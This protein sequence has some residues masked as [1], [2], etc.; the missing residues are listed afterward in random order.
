MDAR[1]P[2]SRIPHL[3]D[4]MSKT[5]DIWGKI[6]ESRVRNRRIELKDGKPILVNMTKD[7]RKSGSLR[8]M[9]HLRASFYLPN[10]IFEKM[11]RRRK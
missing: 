9:K 3:Y 7:K 8:F 5:Y 10:C 2:Q 4:A 6:A 11:N 1:V